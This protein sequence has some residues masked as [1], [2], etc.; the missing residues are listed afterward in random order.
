MVRWVVEFLNGVFK[1]KEIMNT[2]E[3]NELKNKKL[4]P[5]NATKESG[6]T[7]H[8]QLFLPMNHGK[9]TPIIRF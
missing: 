2:K 7:Y 5:N 6:S 4:P 9:I 1:I 8:I 3:I